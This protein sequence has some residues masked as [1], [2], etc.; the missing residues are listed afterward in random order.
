MSSG[1]F[2]IG[3]SG[4]N[5]AQA[6][7]LTTGHNISNAA[8]PGFSRQQILQSNAT[9]QAGGGGFLGTGVQLDSVRRIYSQFLATQQTASQARS[10][11]LDTYY[12][13]LRQLDNVLA[14]P[15]AGLTPALQSF[16]SA[17]QDA[18]A[19]PANLASR[20][21]LV[22]AASALDSR[23]DLLNNRFAELRGAID[24][25]IVATT[26][27]IN[28]YAGEVSRLN[29]A[30]V[31]ARGQAGGQPPNDLLD[32]RDQVVMELNKLIRTTTVAQDDGV[33]N[34]FIGTGQPLVA[35]VQTFQLAAMPD[36]QDPTRT[37]VG[38]RT[39]AG[40]T[41]LPESTLGGGSLGG[42]LAFRSEALDSAKNALGRVAVVLGETFNAQHQLG[43]DL[44]GA[45]GG[46]FF[47]VGAPTVMGST[48]NT[49]DAVL[50]AAYAD[51]GQ[52][53]TSD[54]R[55]AYDGT[56]YT[57]T[58]LSDR[59]TT[60]SA[61]LPVTIDGVA[62]TLASGTFATGDS[63]TIRPTRDGGPNLSVAIVDPALVAL[64]A[65]IRT[66][67]GAANAGNGIVSAGTVNGPAPTDAN[68]RQAVTI[69]F[70]GP[71]TFD[72]TGTG[73]GDPTGLTYT[74]GADIS[75]NGWTLQISGTPAAGDSFNVGANTAGIADNRNG[76]L[77]AGL[78]TGRIVGNGTAT[79]QSAYAAMVGDVG[80]R[81]QTLEVTSRAEA[82][83]L[84]QH[85][86][87]RESFSGVNLDEE[88]ANLVRYQQAYQASGKV[89]QIA[90]VLFETVLQIGGR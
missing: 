27:L 30:I 51:V 19:H 26:E 42:L 62:L 79:L 69:T 66:T 37:T 80:R 33:L 3:L 90:A 44:N 13:Q 56:D 72:V 12:A 63:F 58:R 84:Q 46:S 15:T 28:T 82:T 61:T 25:D 9:P 17:A 39:V 76:L 32:Q 2:G 55:I 41:Q 14:D 60:T 88:A 81:T 16:F 64:G 85:V 77:L 73:T 38:Y 7:L 21:S 65:P 8:T 34:V 52:L 35:G 87:A 6:G 70:T 86:L 89:L 20:Q 1:L 23:F 75:Y 78:Q 68:L 40:V 74:P 47:S 5:A 57:V 48:L 4:L 24:G 11:E 59:V 36:A 50:G 22:S 54:Y 83:L 10:S 18:A 67:A 45:L 53:T 49:G 43:Q 71:N 31:L 29:Q